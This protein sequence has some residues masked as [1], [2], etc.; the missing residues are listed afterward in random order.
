MEFLK[1]TCKRKVTIVLNLL[2]LI[3]VCSQFEYIFAQASVNSGEGKVVVTIRDRSVF[4]PS[5]VD[6]APDP[7]VDVQYYLVFLQR[8][9]SLHEME[10]NEKMA[11]FELSVPEDA[12]DVVL[13]FFYG[14]STGS[15]RYRRANIYVRSGHT[16]SLFIESI[17]GEETIYDKKFGFAALPS[18][19]YDKYRR[20][21]PIYYDSFLVNHPY[22]MVIKY[23]RKTVEKEKISYK[24]VFLTYKNLTIYA[25]R[26]MLNRKTFF[27][28][29]L[30]QS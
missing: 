14:D 22:K 28:S 30:G 13:K 5:S 2:L 11:R 16:E 10:Y 17:E 20:S 15:T 3:L 4:L 8:G 1:I 18:D 9:G 23:C 19:S 26:A 24:Y 29:R 21:L 27:I 25:E 7:D 12:Y 6:K